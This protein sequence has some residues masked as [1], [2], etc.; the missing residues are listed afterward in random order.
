MGL[1]KIIIPYPDNGYEYL[2]IEDIDDILNILF[3]ESIAHSVYK[4]NDGFIVFTNDVERFLEEFAKEL[5]NICEQFCGFAPKEDCNNFRRELNIY[6]GKV[7]HA[8]EREI[9]LRKAKRKTINA[10]KELKE[11]I[12]RGTIK[13]RT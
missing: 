4:S 3:N 11:A 13:D 1:I 8:L 7:K 5:E 2:H 10:L 12:K 6:I 9:K